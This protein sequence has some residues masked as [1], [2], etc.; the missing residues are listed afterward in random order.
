MV[1]RG[2]AIWDRVSAVPFV[3]HVLRSLERFNG[4][5]GGQF[6]A[7]ITYF[8]LLSLAPILMVSFSVA[9]FVLAQRPDLVQSMKDQVTQ[10]IPGDLSARIGSLIDQAI[11]ARLAVGLIGLAVAAFAGIN[12]MGNVREALRAQW[13]P[14]W[15]RPKNLKEN[16]L[17]RYAKDL[18]LLAGLGLI[19]AISF[20]IT[21]FGESLQNLVAGWFGI[22]DQVW[23]RWLLSIGSFLLGVLANLMIFLWMYG[24]LPEKS[25][26]ARRGSLVIGSLVAA[27]VFEILKLLLSLLVTQSAGSPTAAVFGSIIG[28]LFFINIVARVFLMV[29]AWIATDTGTAAETDTAA[30]ADAGAGGGADIGTD[31]G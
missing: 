2:T 7:A 31:G 25:M 29:G 4:R 30:D 11:S 26:R 10:I 13:R 27:V 23:A 5:L 15:E 19:V 8:S 3:A 21:T 6:A 16:F 20:G 28:L 9:G 24:T 12:W 18:G 1:G 22:E 14:V 17:L